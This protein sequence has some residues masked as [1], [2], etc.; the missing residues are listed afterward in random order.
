MGTAETDQTVHAKADPSL[1][2]AHMPF[3]RFFMCWLTCASSDEIYLITCKTRHLQFV[4]QTQQ[5]YVVR[6]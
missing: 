6:E 4:E 3:C 5:K 2:W 1:S